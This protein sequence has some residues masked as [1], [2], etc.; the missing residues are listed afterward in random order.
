MQV[1]DYESNGAHQFIGECQSS[2]AQLKA[3]AASPAP[4]LDLLNPSKAAGQKGYRNSGVL[5]MREVTVSSRP[6]F[7]QYIA[8]GRQGACG[9]GWLTVRLGVAGQLAFWS[10]LQSRWGRSSHAVLAAAHS[11]GMGTLLKMR[12]PPSSA[13]MRGQREGPVMLQADARSASWW[14]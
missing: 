7:L 13:R 10:G 3:L 9:G 12:W 5:S 14:Q 8:G 11:L 1:L 2:L 6:S 4:T